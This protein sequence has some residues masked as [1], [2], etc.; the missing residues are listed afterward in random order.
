LEE[1][2]F[3]FLDQRRQAKQISVFRESNHRNGDSVKNVRHNNVQLVKI[4]LRFV[5]PD[6]I[7]LFSIAQGWLKS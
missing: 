2:H 5:D 3:K 6:F 7:T 4:Y 1:K